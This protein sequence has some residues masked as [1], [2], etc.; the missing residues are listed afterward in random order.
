MVDPLT[1]QLIRKL[2]YQSKVDD[3]Q[4]KEHLFK[5]LDHILTEDLENQEYEFGFTTDIQ[6]DKAPN[7]LNED[8]IRF[9][10]AKKE[11]PEWMLEFRLDAF[12]KWEKMTEPNWAHVTYK[13]PDFQDICYYAAPKQT[14]KYESWDDVDPEMKETMKKLGISLEEQK[15]IDR[16]SS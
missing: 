10:S 1:V 3:V 7:G 5:A 8:I 12:R 9:I 15:K 13:K 2:H 11:E 6:S 14:K 16:C 4:L